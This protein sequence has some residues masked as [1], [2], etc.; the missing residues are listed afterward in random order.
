VRVLLFLTAS[1]VV[2]CGPNGA[3]DGSADAKTSSQGTTAIET[4][5]STSESDGSSES[6]TTGTPGLECETPATETH[7]GDI[8]ISPGTLDQI[9]LLVNVRRID[10]KLEIQ[11]TVLTDLDFLI[12]L[13]EVSKDITLYNNDALVSMAGLDGITLVGDA[14]PSQQ[15]ADP[16]LD[17]WGNI[18]ISDHDALVAIDGLAALQDIPLGLLVSRN[19]ALTDISGLDNLQTV[20]EFAMIRENPMLCASHVMDVLAELAGSVSLVGNAD[21]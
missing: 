3:D 11:D 17:S 2:A 6:S 18:A 12:C 1:C 13:E 16:A 8:Y 7:V 19:G 4:G 5:A 15:D 10:G 20:G 9:D 14:P 21:C